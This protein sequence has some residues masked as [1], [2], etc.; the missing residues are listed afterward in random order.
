MVAAAR[1]LRLLAVLT[2]VVLGGCAIRVGYQVL[3][4]ALLWSLGKYIDWEGDQ[5]RHARALI[6][7]LHEWHRQRELPRYASNL[8]ALADDLENHV[9]AAVVT[10]HGD[11]LTASWLELAQR[12]ADPAATLLSGLSPQQ[13]DALLAT[14]ADQEHQQ[15]RDYLRRSPAEH[16]R[17][18]AAAMTGAIERLTGRLSGD[19]RRLIETWSAALPDSGEQSLAQHSAWRRHFAAAL[20]RRGD[21]AQLQ[22][23]LAQL[24]GEPH[25]LWSEKYRQQMAAS[26]QLT[27]QLLADLA[28]ALS[29][30][31][32]RRA[33][34]RLRD[35]ATE[36]D[37]LSTPPAAAVAAHHSGRGR[38][39][40]D[41]DSPR[42]WDRA[43]AAGP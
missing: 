1:V 2:A 23:E 33:T 40:R 5:K 19:Q 15:R 28:N 18:H 42:A 22:A 17:E 20:D 30:G 31:Q 24:F 14:L 34:Q 6:R 27:V 8:R 3:D 43:S 16:R 11:A 9:D 4:T 38:A 26:E 13:T 35:I 29:A 37:G 21:P 41:A 36:L 7:E 12:L 32:R 25:S 10:R 39:G